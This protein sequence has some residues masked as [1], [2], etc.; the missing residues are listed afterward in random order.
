MLKHSVELIGMLLTL[1]YWCVG[2]A[3]G[4]LN[5]RCDLCEKNPRRKCSNPF[6]KKYFKGDPIKAQCSAPIGVELFNCAT[7][8]VVSDLSNVSLEVSAWDPCLGWA[9]LSLQFS[10]DPSFWVWMWP[11]GCKNWHAQCIAQ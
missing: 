10:F 5:S 1:I 11:Y 8:T 9:S 3:L 4:C 7:G 6:E 2:R